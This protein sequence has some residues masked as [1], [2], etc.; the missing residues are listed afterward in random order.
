M[1]FYYIALAVASA[2]CTSTDGL[3]AVSGSTGHTLLRIDTITGQQQN[4]EGKTRFLVGE[5]TDASP[6]KTPN[7]NSPSTLQNGKNR[8][9]KEELFDDSSDSSSSE[10]ENMSRGS[11]NASDGS[12]SSS[13]EEEESTSKKR[14]KKLNHL[15]SYYGF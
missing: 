13:N 8:R 2:L 10:L 3:E 1:R 14:L 11:N 7:G 15:H 5:S 6:A 12:T 9:L 4:D